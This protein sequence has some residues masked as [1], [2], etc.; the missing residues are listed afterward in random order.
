M[1]CSKLLCS[2]PGLPCCLNCWLLVS[3][4]WIKSILP[5]ILL[6]IWSPLSRE[7]WFP[8]FLKSGLKSDYVPRMSFDFHLLIPS[9]IKHCLETG[10]LWFSDS[11]NK[12]P[13]Y[14]LI[15][16]H[17][18]IIDK[19]TMRSILDY[20]QCHCWEYLSEHTT[21]PVHYLML[22]SI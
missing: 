6:T 13:D 9:L 8:D 11:R 18:V 1:F 15:S 10:I 22:C 12:W 16:V 14:A 2:F 17:C 20:P 19:I 3:L 4:L 7:L 5:G 21:P